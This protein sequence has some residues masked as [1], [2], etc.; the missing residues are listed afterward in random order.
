MLQLLHKG[1]AAP[2]VVTNAADLVLGKDVVWI[3]FVNPTREEELAVE[4]ALRL[5]LPTREEM[6]EIET[7][8]RLYRE[9]GALYMT[10]QLLVGSQ[11][12]APQIG[13]CTFVLAGQR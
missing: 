10:A 11:G 9:G 12:E 3:D 8:S 2:V 5:Q 4:A 6:A 13:P 7:S 1:A